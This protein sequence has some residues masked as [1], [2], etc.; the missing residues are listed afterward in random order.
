MVS[1]KQ[2]TLTY[3]D[4]KLLWCSYLQIQSHSLFGDQP[5][6]AQDV[7]RHLVPDCHLG[8]VGAP[9]LSPDLRHGHEG[10]ADPTHPDEHGR[11][12]LHR[13]LRRGVGRVQEGEIGLLRLLLGRSGNFKDTFFPKFF[14]KIV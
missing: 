10:G 3:F 13:V 8:F 14:K 12:H 5:D 9:L 2:T 1:S 11:R 6:P 4:C 7:D